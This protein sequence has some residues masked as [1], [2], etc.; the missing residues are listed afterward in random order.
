MNQ[1]LNHP[2]ADRNPDP[3]TNAPGAHPIGTGIGAAG[4][5]VT[6]AA[7]GSLAGPVG[8]AVGAV[9]GAVVGGLALAFTHP[10]L[11]LAVV[12]A[13]SLSFACF[14]WWLWRRVFRRT[15]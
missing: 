12:M 5:A 1:D 9:V 3:I 14:V 7:A 15:A 8:T 6:G 10:W 13:I 11:A 4:G 2:D